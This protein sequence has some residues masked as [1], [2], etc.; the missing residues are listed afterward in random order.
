MMIFSTADVY[1]MKEIINECDSVDEVVQ[2]CDLF[3]QYINEILGMN[4]L[5]FS[6]K[7]DLKR[8]ANQ[9]INEL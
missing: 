3:R 8:T 7:E 5:S 4:C 1:R 6:I 2:Y 9:K